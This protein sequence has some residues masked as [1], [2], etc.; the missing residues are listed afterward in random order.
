[1]P[2]LLDFEDL[3]PDMEFDSISGRANPWVTFPDTIMAVHVDVNGLINVENG[4]ITFDSA[5]AG[6]SVLDQTVPLPLNVGL[7]VTYT[8]AGAGINGPG[9]GVFP[10]RN[11]ASVLIDDALSIGG[12]V[13][14]EN[15]ILDFNTD[16]TFFR[17]WGPWAMTGN[18][19]LI[20]T[21]SQTGSYFSGISV[22][23]DQT[24]APE[25]G[26]PVTIATDPADVDDTADYGPYGLSAG[27]TSDTT[28]GTNKMRVAVLGYMK[29]ADWTNVTDEAA[30]TLTVGVRYYVGSSGKIT[31][32]KPSG[33]LFIMEV[34]IATAVDTLYVNIQAPKSAAYEAQNFIAFGNAG[35]DNGGIWVTNVARTV[36]RKITID[37]TG[38]IIGVASTPPGF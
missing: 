10:I 18:A 37:D 19:Q 29:K 6:I 12:S 21:Y 13:E 22:D 17:M 31:K 14:G 34:G 27:L 5:T 7:S 9:S 26:T 11:F 20:P 23:T 16:Q 32:T 35:V 2:T 1:M 30:A 38:T 28:L 25:I 4:G 36:W 3:K 15:Q 33:A 24:A 8:G